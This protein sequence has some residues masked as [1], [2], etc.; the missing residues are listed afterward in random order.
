MILIP[1]STERCV[2]SCRLGATAF[3]S[4]LQHSHKSDLYL[5]SS[6]ET[7]IREPTLYKLLTFPNPNPISIFCRLGCLSKESIQVLGSFW[8]FVTNLFFLRWRVVSPTPNP[9]A[10]RTTPCCLSAAAY[11]IYSQ[12]RSIAGGRSS[13]TW[14]C[15]MLWWQGPT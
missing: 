12:L 9:Q 15:A 14:G 11:S 6:L 5:D 2:F 8:I 1:L 13:A 4:D 10:W 7:V 3:P